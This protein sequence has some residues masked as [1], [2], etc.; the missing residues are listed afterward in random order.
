[1][2][3]RSLPAG[4]VGRTVT[5]AVYQRIEI[6]FTGGAFDDYISAIAAVTT[7]RSAFWDKFFPAETA[8]AIAAVAGFD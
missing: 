5:A 7:I 1:V 8:A 3:I 4:A 6:L 2:H